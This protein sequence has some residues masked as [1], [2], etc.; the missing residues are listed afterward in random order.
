MADIVRANA[1]DRVMD[2]WA[3]GRLVA[4]AA[5][6]DGSKE[7]K[8][9]L[10]EEL[11]DVAAELA[12]PDP[13]PVERMLADTA[14]IA[15][16]DHRYAEANYAAAGIEGGMTI[17]QSENNQRRIDRTHRRLMATLKTLAAVRRLAGAGPVVQINVARQ[18][19]NQLNAGDP[20]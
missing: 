14:A 17:A 20:S 5:G 2:G 3:V 1:A 19:F 12:G 7:T 18:Q 16:F 13:S 15:W 4:W 11:G 8:A 9:K 6:K 10:R